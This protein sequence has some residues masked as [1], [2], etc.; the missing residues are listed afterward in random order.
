MWGPFN[1]CMC[2]YVFIVHTYV[3]VHTCGGQRL[4]VGVLL[5]TRSLFI[6]L[7]ALELTL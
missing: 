2:A 7:A 5:E 1:L 3:P 4:M 6:A